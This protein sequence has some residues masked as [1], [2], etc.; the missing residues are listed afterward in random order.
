MNKVD[1]V[2]SG[3][4]KANWGCLS[5]AVILVIAPIIIVMEGFLYEMYFKERLLEASS[6]PDD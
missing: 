1:T 2:S 4:K 5:L 3:R 6:S